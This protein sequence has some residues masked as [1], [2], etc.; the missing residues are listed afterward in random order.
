VGL[1]HNGQSIDQAMRKTFSVSYDDFQRQWEH[2]QPR[3]V[4]LRAS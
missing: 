4:G 3:P 1:I 2:N